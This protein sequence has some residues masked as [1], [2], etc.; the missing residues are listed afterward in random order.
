MRS[1]CLKG[2][3]GYY[4]QNN[5]LTEG[6]LKIKIPRIVFNIFIKKYYKVRQCGSH[7]SIAYRKQ[8]KIA[9]SS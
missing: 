2:G 6:I 7:C 3:L 9:R 8:E 1:G 5:I 4:V